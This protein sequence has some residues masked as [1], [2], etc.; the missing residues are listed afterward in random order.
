[1]KFHPAKGRPVGSYNVPEQWK[2][3]RK[4]IMSTCTPRCGKAEVADEVGKKDR[5]SETQNYKTWNKQNK[6]TRGTYSSINKF[7]MG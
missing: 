6:N 4:W 2:Y 7:Q 3:P 1:M 5:I